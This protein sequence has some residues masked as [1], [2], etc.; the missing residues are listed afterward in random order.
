MGARSASPH[1]HASAPCPRHA[2]RDWQVPGA[3]DATVDRSLIEVLLHLLRPADAGQNPDHVTVHF[4][5][6]F[7]PAPPAVASSAREARIEL[8]DP[9]SDGA[10]GF[11]AM[12]PVVLGDLLAAIA[13]ESA[14]EARSLA[15]RYAFGEKYA[16]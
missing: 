15:A 9:V 6:F 13:I 5:S 2:N 11:V 1:V 14:A 7:G 3:E 16:S 10:L 4:R 12:R 8:R